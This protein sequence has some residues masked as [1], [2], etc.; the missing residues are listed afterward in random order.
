MIVWDIK[1]IPENFKS[2]KNDEMITLL[3]EHYQKQIE[4]H[5]GFE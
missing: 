3:N 1:T 4:R 5:V 2:S